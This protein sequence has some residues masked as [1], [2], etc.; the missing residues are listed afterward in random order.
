MVGG[1]EIEMRRFTL[2]SVTLGPRVLYLINTVDTLALLEK[3][4]G[5]QTNEINSDIR[6][7]SH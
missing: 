2:T 7:G 6:F 4:T 5:T 3:G 1:W